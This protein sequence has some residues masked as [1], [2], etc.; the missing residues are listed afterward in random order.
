LSTIDPTS[1]K[2]GG[3]AV[4][5]AQATPT[6]GSGGTVLAHKPTSGPSHV[7]VHFGRRTIV[8]III[9]AVVVAAGLAAIHLYRVHEREKAQTELGV[10]AEQVAGQPPTV[11]VVKVEAAGAGVSLTLPGQC[12]A[13]YEATIYGRVNGYLHK[14]NFD[15]GDRVKEGDV[16]AT[17]DTPELDQEIKVAQA[18]LASLQADVTLAQA[19]ADFAKITNQRFEAGAPE[20]VVSQQDADQKK[21]E[22]GVSLAKLESAKAQVQL[23]T[24]DVHRLQALAD[25]KSVLSPFAGV[26]T[27]RHTDIGDLV[28]AG[29]TSNTTALFTVTQSDTIRVFVDVPQVAR[30]GIGVGMTADVAAREFSGREFHG[31]V[32]RTAQAI[33]PAAGTLRVE[34]LAPNKEGTLLPGMFVEVTFRSER[35][36]PPVVIPAGA[37]LLLVD[38]PHVAV[39][40]ADNCVHMRPIKISRDLGDTI[41]LSDGLS[42]G[43]TIALNLSNQI[44]DGQ[45]VAPVLT[46]KSGNRVAA[47]PKEPLDAGE[48]P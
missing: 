15:I 4:P 48:Q 27:Q 5:P 36:H 32:D 14:W 46:A 10:G 24:A 26:V 33:N 18:K 8:R 12:S 41:E 11:H 39:V 21:S 29:S 37:L 30:P 25:F 6:Q 40:G 1:G 7:P 23:G 9:G 35:S 42:G 2:D 47:S 19:T 20:G 13:F 3:K 44:T 17:I 28:T 34:V 31:K 16:L 22:L 38:G 45:K 43:E